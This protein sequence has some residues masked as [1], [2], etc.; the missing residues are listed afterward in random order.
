[1]I[2][3]NYS[4]HIYLASLHGGKGNISKELSGCRGSEVQGGAV[5]V[6]I[7]LTHSIAIQDLEDLVE[8]ELADSYKTILL[9][10]H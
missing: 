6:G 9:I 5:Q 7:L 3:S 10:Q 2:G 4:N 8:T 1:M